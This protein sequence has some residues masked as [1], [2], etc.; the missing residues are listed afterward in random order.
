MLS[1]YESILKS[2]NSGR[3]SLPLEFSKFYTPKDSAKAIRDFCS[4]YEI[5]DRKLM[6]KIEK[7]INDFINNQR[8]M[9][10]FIDGDKLQTHDVPVKMFRFVKDTAFKDKFFA[11]TKSGPNGL[12]VVY[13]DKQNTV[14]LI[15]HAFFNNKEK[16]LYIK[17]D[18][19]FTIE[20]P[21]ESYLMK[22]LK[23][24]I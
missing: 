4:Y 13:F 21:E 20:I 6:V 16:L 17:E 15:I 23:K 3:A 8:E 11:Q 7:S 1:L 12:D 5:K 14:F 24:Y 19:V 9:E 22:F 10:Y 2:T 18:Y